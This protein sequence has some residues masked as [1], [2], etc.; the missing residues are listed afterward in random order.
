MYC[1]NDNGVNQLNPASHFILRSNGKNA[2][3][4]WPTSEKLEALRDQWF[5]APNL[6]AQKKIAAQIQLQAFEDVPYIPLG[7]SISPTAYRKDIV[8][9]LNGQPTFWN[10]KRQG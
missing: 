9:V 1:I 6:D 2:S 3:F 10:V 7:Q 5:D 4:G 8:G